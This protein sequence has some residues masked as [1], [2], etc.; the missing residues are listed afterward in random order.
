MATLRT[1]SANQ[2]P[3]PFLNNLALKAHGCLYRHPRKPLLKSLYNLLQD[4]AITVRKHK[5]FILISLNV[6]VISAL[7]ATHALTLDPDNIQALIPPPLQELLEEWKKQTHLERDPTSSIA[8]TGCYLLNNTF[9]TAL[10][11][12][13]GLTFGILSLY[14][15]FQNGVG[16]GTFI[17]ELAEANAIGHF[18]ISIAPHGVSELMGSTIAGV[19]GLL[20]GWTMIN[21]GEYTH[22]CAL[23]RIGKEAVS[24]SL[25]VSP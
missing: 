5:T 7:L 16:L 2:E 1:Y 21:P 19:G 15:L 3:I 6:Q 4:A 23:K 17:K 20:I 14:L 10:V 25:S 12:A 9:V 18:L 11:L 13:G 8:M 24:C 22:R